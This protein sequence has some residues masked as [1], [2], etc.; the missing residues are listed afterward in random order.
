MWP[1][2][3]KSSWPLASSLSVAVL[4]ALMRLLSALRLHRR[5]GS[6][7]FLGSLALVRLVLCPLC[8]LLG[9]SPR[10]AVQ[11]SG[12]AAATVKDRCEFGLQL[13]LGRLCLLL[14]QA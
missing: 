8:L 3:L 12:G 13:V 6:L 2:L 14:R 10:L 5:S 4:L 1:R 7:L 11:S 9:S